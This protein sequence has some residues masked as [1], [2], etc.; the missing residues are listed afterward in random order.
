[1]QEQPVDA[2]APHRLVLGWLRQIAA[3]GTRRGQLVDRLKVRATEVAAAESEGVSAG[4]ELSRLRKVRDQ[5][6]GSR[7][8]VGR[9][10]A[11]ELDEDLSNIIR[12]EFDSLMPSCAVSIRTSIV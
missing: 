9:R 3:L 12:S 1:V 6:S 11:K 8:T 10:L 2:E 4:D 5:L 7:E